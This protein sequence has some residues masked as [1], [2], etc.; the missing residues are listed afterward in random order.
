MISFVIILRFHHRV[1][2][3]QAEDVDGDG[4]PDERDECPHSDRSA[5]VVIGGCD[6][7]VTNTVFPSGCTLAD[8][9]ADC[10]DHAR[11]PR[12][13]VRCVARL[14]HTMKRIGIITDQ[15]KDA[16]RSCAVQAD[17]P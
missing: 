3:P 9:L 13:F 1:G 16:I 8:L 17:L 11:K 2:R 6:S 7:E 5:T 10:A 15:Q 12:K 4:V 14:T